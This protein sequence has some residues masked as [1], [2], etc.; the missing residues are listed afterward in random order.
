MET[1][2]VCSAVRTEFFNIIY[3][4]CGFK[5]LKG[6]RRHCVWQ[7]AAPFGNRSPVDLAYGQSIY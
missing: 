3:E 5:V 6:S 4:S 7:K 2:R 1:G